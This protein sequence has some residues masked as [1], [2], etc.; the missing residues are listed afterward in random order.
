MREA[1]QW[2]RK[3]RRWRATTLA[4]SLHRDNKKLDRAGE[5]KKSTFDFL[6]MGELINLASFSLLRD[7]VDNVVLAAREPWRR[8]GA[9][10]MGGPFSA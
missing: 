2:L 8:G 1:A 5:A 4:W 10:P 3:P 7:N 9:I 6:S